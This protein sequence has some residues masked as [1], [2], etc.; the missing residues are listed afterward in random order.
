[1]DINAAA[2]EYGNGVI[3]SLKKNRRI[4]IMM[5]L[6]AAGM[7][8][9]AVSL[10]RAD[11]YLSGAFSDM[12]SVYI[13]SKGSQSLGMNFINSLALNAAFMLAHLYS[14]YVRSG[15]R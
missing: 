9:G 5:L 13:R 14:G 15:C 3:T 8:I 2:K 12:F 11:S 7:I 10:R 1:M 6:F 4:L